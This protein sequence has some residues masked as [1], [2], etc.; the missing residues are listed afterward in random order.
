MFAGANICVINFQLLV[1][2]NPRESKRSTKSLKRHRHFCESSG[3]DLNNFSEVWPFD[4]F[5]IVLTALCQLS[6]GFL[7]W[8]AIGNQN[9]KMSPVFRWSVSFLYWCSTWRNKWQIYVV[10]A[11]MQ[12]LSARGRLILCNRV[13]FRFKQNFQQYKRSYD[14]MLIDWVR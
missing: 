2:Q 13:L 3:E 7:A 11:F 1:V 10:E 8:I 12:L 6:V 5:D 14:K 9:E 4:G